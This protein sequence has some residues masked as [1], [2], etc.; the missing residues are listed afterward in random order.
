MVW[1]TTSCVDHLLYQRTF[2]TWKKCEMWLQRWIEEMI[3]ALTEQSKQ[4]SLMCTLKCSGDF[5][6]FHAHDLCNTGLQCSYQQSYEATRIWEGQLV[7]L[8]CSHERNVQISSSFIAQLVRALHRHCRGH[9]I[10]SPSSHLK[11]FSSAHMRPL[12]KWSSKCQD[13]FFNSRLC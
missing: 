8:M 3:L 4:L 6:G 11:I 5:N 7:G 1:D 2:A 13:D 12:L 9:G 10:E